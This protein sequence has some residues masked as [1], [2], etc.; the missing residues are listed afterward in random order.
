MAS[1]DVCAFAN[2]HRN[3]FGQADAFFT[4]GFGGGWKHWWEFTVAKVRR[5]NKDFGS[6]YSGWNC[7]EPLLRRHAKQ[8]G[9]PLVRGFGHARDWRRG[10]IRRA[11]AWVRRETD[12][13]GPDGVEGVLPE[14][15]EHVRLCARASV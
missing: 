12:E 6:R 7:I 14:A 4:H 2:T 3:R 11:R 5:A 1:S 8:A 9:T 10:I 15:D 13:E